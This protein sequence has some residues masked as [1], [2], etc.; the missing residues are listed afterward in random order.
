M[1]GGT[2][3]QGKTSVSQ[4][5]HACPWTEGAKPHISQ[6]EPAGA[7]VGKAAAVTRQSVRLEIFSLGSIC[8][9]G[10][11]RAQEQQWIPLRISD[12]SGSQ[13]PAYGACAGLGVPDESPAAV[14]PRPEDGLSPG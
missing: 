7:S 13:A 8:V 2:S 4:H 9:V 10:G 1:K 14:W 6:P 12:S 5:A 11:G 3:I